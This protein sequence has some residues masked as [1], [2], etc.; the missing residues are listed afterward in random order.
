MAPNA[1]NEC[2]LI[3]AL[4]SYLQIALVVFLPQLQEEQTVS[5]GAAERAVSL[6][7]GCC[8]RHHSG[9]TAHEHNVSFFPGGFVS[10]SHA[11]GLEA[12]PSSLATCPVG[13]ALDAAAVVLGLV[14]HDLVLRRF[15]RRALCL[16]A[17]L[18]CCQSSDAASAWPFAAR[19]PD[20]P[21]TLADVRVASLGQ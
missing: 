3:V 21:G 15:G 14:D 4:T 11:S 2:R 20:G 18:F 19:L 12:S 10:V 1:V 7:N 5:T 9:E 16:G 13:F 8:Q 6:Q 17:C